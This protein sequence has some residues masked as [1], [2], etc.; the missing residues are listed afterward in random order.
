MY[1]YDLPV[2]FCPTISSCKALVVHTIEASKK[3]E[4][5]LWAKLFLLSSSLLFAFVKLLFSKW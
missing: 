4:I 3:S 1:Y 2:S 5:G